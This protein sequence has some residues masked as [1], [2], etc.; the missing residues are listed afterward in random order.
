MKSSPLK[1][2]HINDSFIVPSKTPGGESYFLQKINH[3][4]FKDVAGLQNN[5][6]QVTTHYGPN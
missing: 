2:G 3:H 4:I 6:Q 1:I 5:I